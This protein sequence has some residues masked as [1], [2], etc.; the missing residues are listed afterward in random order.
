MAIQDADPERRNLMVCSLAFIVYYYAGGKPIE[1]EIR[2]HVVNVMF[3]NTVAL[4]IF[5]WTMLLWF[6]LRYWQTHQ[7]EYKKAKN[8]D[9]KKQVNN[10]LVRWLISRETKLEYRKI[11]G[12]SP[13]QVVVS[14]GKWYVE[15]SVWLRGAV[16]DK[17]NVL[18]VSGQDERK[19][20]PLSGL[21]GLATKGYIHIIAAVTM[22]GFTSYAVPY[23][24]FI[25]AISAPLVT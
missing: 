12:F 7:Y 17:G 3:E 15:Y 9:I 14:E 10:W 20:R 25:M 11:N 23:I 1:P 6:G 21:L 19:T 5:A 16:D 13:K 24:L 8:N 4:A 18:S 2:L 22:Q